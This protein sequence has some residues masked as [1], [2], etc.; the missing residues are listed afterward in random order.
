MFTYE[1]IK[2]TSAYIPEFLLMLLSM[3]NS[4]KGAI[5]DFDVILLNFLIESYIL[6]ISLAA[7][8]S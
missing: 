8:A 7:F 2:S 5:N 4:S 1:F 3:R 6:L